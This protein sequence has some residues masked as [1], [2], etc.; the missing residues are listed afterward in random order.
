MSESHQPNRFMRHWP[1]LAALSILLCA[2]N[3]RSEI[4]RAVAAVGCF[5]LM[6]YQSLIG[7]RTWSGARFVFLSLIAGNVGLVSVWLALNVVRF[8]TYAP[9]S[10][11]IWSW[12]ELVICVQNSLLWGI[13]AVAVIV[14]VWALL[15]FARWVMMQVSAAVI[16]RS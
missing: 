10:E 7:R 5:S 15:H 3:L 13:A 9:E 14:S 12:H 4:V 16:D 8:Y 11:R 1:L 6:I 2:A